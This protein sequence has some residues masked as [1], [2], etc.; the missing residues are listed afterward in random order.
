MADELDRGLPKD[1][2]TLLGRARADL[3]VVEFAFKQSLQHKGR[4]HLARALGT[5]QAL[6]V[7]AEE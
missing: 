5:V 4:E 7:I 2:Y 3:A 1:F 6:S